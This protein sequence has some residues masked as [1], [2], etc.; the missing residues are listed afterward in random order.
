MDGT[1]QSCTKFFK[2]L[3][4]IHGFKNGHY[5]SLAFCLLSK[6]SE[7]VY[8][9]C[10]RTLVNIC[11]DKYSLRLQPST[12]VVDF[13]QAIQKSI[14]TVWQNTEIIGCRFHVS[15]AWYRKLN[16]L[17]L[18]TEYQDSNSAIGNWLKWT[19][20]LQYLNPT[21][22]ATSFAEDLMPIMPAD[23]RLSNYSTY[24]NQ[25]YIQ[26]TSLFAPTIWASCT[27][28][29]FRTTNACESFHNYF[30]KKFYTAFPSLY[31]F[32][33]AVIDM[34]ITVYVKID[35]INEQK[36]M[37]NKSKQREKSLEFNISRYKT[38]EISRLHFLQCMCHHFANIH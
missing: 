24:L 12:I 8:V 36:K 3:F 13:E 18:S 37:R 6:K 9:N 25:N 14:K 2:Q 30:S 35:S 7:D 19:F 16:Q 33:D 29:M 38:K 11:S 15:Q 27:S 10:F 32:I 17:G 23:S 5:I 20:G 22:V 34:Q 21:E 28:N 26:E 1:F 4:T 31:K